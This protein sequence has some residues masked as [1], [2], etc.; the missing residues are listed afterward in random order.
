MPRLS[1]S[2]REVFWLTLVVGLGVGW[3]V[4][5]QHATTELS[6][7]NNR[8]AALE[9]VLTNAGAQLNDDGTM[10]STLNGIAFSYAPSTE[11]Q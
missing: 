10:T 9:F 8:L 5:S 11:Q 4:Q 6:A 7:T 1:F 3:W 2:L